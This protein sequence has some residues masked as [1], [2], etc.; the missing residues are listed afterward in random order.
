MIKITFSLSISSLENI[1]QQP[2]TTTYQV[3][4]SIAFSFFFP[5]ITCLSSLININ[6]IMLQQYLKTPRR[7][8][9]Y[10]SSSSQIKRLVLYHLAYIIDYSY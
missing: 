4:R 2:N 3:Y 9:T 7:A 10:R 8:S 6:V 1:P 5:S